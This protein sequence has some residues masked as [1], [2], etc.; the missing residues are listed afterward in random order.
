MPLQEGTSQSVISEN[1][2]K[3]IDKGK[4]QKQAVAI[5]L[6][7]AGKSSVGDVLSYLKGELEKVDDERP[8]S[9]GQGQIEYTKSGIFGD[10]TYNIMPKSEKIKELEKVMDNLKKEFNSIDGG[11]GSGNFNHG[12][13]PGKVGGGT[14]GGKPERESSNN[15]NT[16]SKETIVE[17]KETLQHMFGKSTRV[18][19]VLQK[20]LEYIKNL[21]G[22]G[23]ITK[24]QYEDLIN[25]AYR[26]FG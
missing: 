16:S 22:D 24:T 17:V 6:S 8:F 25:Y 5:A 4:P 18:E 12:G 23:K 9:T 14:S 15:G 21:Y 1:I 13:R 3:E 26:H 7:K 11:Q 20:S 19:N 10:K 2:K